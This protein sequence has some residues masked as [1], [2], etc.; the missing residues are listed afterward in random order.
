MTEGNDESLFPSTHIFCEFSHSKCDYIDE[1][2]TF[3]GY[4]NFKSSMNTDADDD[5]FCDD[6]IKM[7]H[8]AMNEWETR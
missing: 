7:L 2:Y 4:V 5:I 8:I 1:R 3:S 6:N